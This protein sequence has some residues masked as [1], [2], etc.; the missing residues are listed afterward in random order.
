VIFLIKSSKYKKIKNRNNLP[1]HVMLLPSVIIL[2]IYCYGPMVGI[3]IAFQKYNPTKGMFASPFV[4]FE[5]F[6]YMLVLPDTFQIL[7]N[8]IF[9]ALMKIIGGL[10]VPIMFSLLLN[11]VRHGSFKRSVQTIVYIPHFLSWVILSGILIDILSPSE[12][13]VNQLI[14][15]VGFK[16]VYFLGNETIFPYVLSV[17]H[18][19][20]DFGFGT[21]IYLASITSIDLS[22]YEAA[23]VDGANKLKQTINITLPGMA[24]IIIVMATLSMGNILNAGFEQVFNLYSPIVYKTGDIIDTFVYRLGILDAQYGVATAVGLFKSVVSFI[25][26]VVAYRLAYKLANYRIF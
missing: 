22:L 3:V 1:L 21:I 5:N 12:G 14:N 11:E 13:I 18:I 15:L 25:F 20:K 17:T 9:I 6:E 16:S 26:V 2:L 24:P 19:W 8:T 10:I 23:I 4:G 7:W